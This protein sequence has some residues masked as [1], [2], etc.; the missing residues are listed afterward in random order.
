MAAGY[1]GTPLAKKLGLKPGL[2][3][4]FQGASAEFFEDLFDP[5]SG[6]GEQLADGLARKKQLRAPLDYVHLFVTRRAQLEVDFARAAACLE[7][8]GILWV[9]WPKGGAK[10]QIPT[11]L[12][13]NVV[14]EV[15]LARGLVDIKVCAV[16]GVWS[17][18]R[19]AFRRSR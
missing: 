17:G 1:S 6:G 9:S 15:G 12:N 11:D 19:F 18:L 10:A 2:R 3:A 7:P 4:Y 8:G 5:D 16:D 13:E 14:R